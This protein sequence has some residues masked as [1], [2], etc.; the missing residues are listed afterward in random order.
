LEGFASKAWIMYVN[1]EGVFREYCVVS[2][3]PPLLSREW[4]ALILTYP[5][6]SCSFELLNITLDRS[7]R[8]V[9]I[10]ISNVGGSWLNVAIGDRQ[11]K[12]EPG[13]STN[14]KVENLL[15]VISFNFESSLGRAE[16]TVYAIWR[17]GVNL[18]LSLTAIIILIPSMIIASYGILEYI[19]LKRL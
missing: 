15:E 18:L 19:V 8:N 17:E 9:T 4:R 12:L 10:T 11:L 14:V 3:I 2:I 5:K 13:G 1:V 6:G 7:Y 16:V